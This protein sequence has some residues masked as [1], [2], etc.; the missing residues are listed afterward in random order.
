MIQCAQNQLEE[1]YRNECIVPD[2]PGLKKTYLRVK[3]RKYRPTSAPS[4]KRMINPIE[5]SRACFLSC[6]SM[7]ESSLVC[8]E[9]ETVDMFEFESVAALEKS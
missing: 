5:L 4:G 1:K 7:I 6:S 2:E 9:G 3:V 8:R